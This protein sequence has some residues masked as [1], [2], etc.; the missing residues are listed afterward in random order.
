MVVLV[1]KDGIMGCNN[2]VYVGGVLIGGNCCFESVL[3]V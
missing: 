3:S 1:V 2:L